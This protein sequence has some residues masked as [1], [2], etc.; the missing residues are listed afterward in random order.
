M[1]VIVESHSGGS[2]PIMLKS[3]RSIR[4]CVDYRKWLV[5]QSL[6]HIQ[7]H[8]CWCYELLDPSATCRESKNNLHS[9][10][11]RVCSNSGCYRLGCPEPL[12][13]FSGSWTGC[14]R[15][16][17]MWLPTFMMSSFIVTP[18][19][20]MFIWWQRYSSHWGGHGSRPKKC[21]IGQRELRYLGH[22]LD[23]GWVHPQVENIGRKGDSDPVQWTR[24][25]KLATGSRSCTLQTSSC[26]LPCRS[27][28]W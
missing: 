28:H 18:G 14:S 16:L 1:G 3:D 26:P 2:S 19:S 9:P 11:H 15:T 22:H 8:G 21:V 5:C 6:M 12:T 4:F 10:L 17:K 7:C 13:P 20:S 27:K 25:I 24:I 23:G